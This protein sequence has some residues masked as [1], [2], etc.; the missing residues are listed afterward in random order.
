M[1]KMLRHSFFPLGVKL[2]QT[3]WVNDKY[4]LYR[5]AMSAWWLL[6]AHVRL[7]VCL[8]ACL[9]VTWQSRGLKARHVD[10]LNYI[11]LSLPTHPALFHT[12]S[13][14]LTSKKILQFLSQ[15]GRHWKY[16]YFSPR[17]GASG[18]TSIFL[19]GRAP[20][21]VLLVFSQGG[22]HWKYF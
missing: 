22:R 8:L 12:Y 14:N 2:G 17:E 15:G 5:S 3:L 4:R 19:P 10:W 9:Y 13:G 18:S 6:I 20:L 7:S 1:C 21:E 11:L 16:F